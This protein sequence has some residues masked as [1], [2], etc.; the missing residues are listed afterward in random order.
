MMSFQTDI[1]EDKDYVEPFHVQL[2][3]DTQQDDFQASALLDTGVDCKILSYDA[4][5]ALGP[6]PN[7]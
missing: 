5:M 1:S 6:N 2:I 7:W 3:N 4:W